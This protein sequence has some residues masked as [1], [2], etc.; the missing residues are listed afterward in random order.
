MAI[1]RR[2][3]DLS[4]RGLAR[5]LWISRRF[6]FRGNAVSPRL[7]F[8]WKWRS[9]VASQV[10]AVRAKTIAWRSQLQLLGKQSLLFAE[11]IG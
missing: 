5:T 10:R 11:S 6:V 2:L 8:S 9:L 3:G 1:T 7:M 4:A